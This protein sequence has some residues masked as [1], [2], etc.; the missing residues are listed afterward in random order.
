MAVKG[1]MTNQN[2]RNVNKFQPI[3]SEYGISMIGNPAMT[4]TVVNMSFLIGF[5]MFGIIDWCVVIVIKLCL[6][7]A[8]KLYAPLIL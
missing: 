7:F 3:N 5:F 2:S 8:C 4:I 6:W 1:V